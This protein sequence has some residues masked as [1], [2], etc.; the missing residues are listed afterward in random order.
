MATPAS[1][2][3]DWLMDVP[4]VVE[5]VLGGST[6]TVRDC[7]DFEPNKVVRLSLSAGSDLDMRVEGIPIATG[8]VVIVEDQTALRI[9][10]IL[11][12]PGVDA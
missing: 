6:V 3:M 7:L 2:S 10:R 8:E 5:F 1:V 9:T 11:P 12:P 4:C